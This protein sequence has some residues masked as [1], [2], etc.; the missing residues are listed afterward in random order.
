MKLLPS[1]VEAQYVAFRWNCL[2]V[3]T[4][5]EQCL[6]GSVANLLE[7][8]VLQV[9]M[10]IAVQQSQL[11]NWTSGINLLDCT[12]NNVHDFSSGNSDPKLLI[13]KIAHYYGMG[14]EVRLS[15]EK[16]FTMDLSTFDPL[17]GVTVCVEVLVEC[18]PWSC[19]RHEDGTSTFRSDCERRAR[20]FRTSFYLWL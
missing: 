2:M 10:K 6:L 14:Y 16:V 4:A 17:G 19:Q 9:G 13:S 20:K 15:E 7:N 18:I 12:C 11:V 5:F 1:N 8:N 3:G